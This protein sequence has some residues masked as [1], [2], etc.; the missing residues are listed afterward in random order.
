M[1]S[2]TFARAAL[3]AA[4]CSKKSMP[5]YLSTVEVE[6]KGFSSKSKDD[7]V[8]PMEVF[9]SIDTNGDGVLSKEEFMQAVEKM[10]YVSLLLC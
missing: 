2:S 4:R 5:R 6:S 9:D 3:T 7:A 10:H 8:D 1:L